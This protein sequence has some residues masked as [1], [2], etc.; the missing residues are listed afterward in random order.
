MQPLPPFH[1]KKEYRLPK[2]LHHQRPS[3]HAMSFLPT[4]STLNAG[5]YRFNPKASDGSRN[6]TLA[7]PAR[8][9]QTSGNKLEHHPTPNLRPEDLRTMRPRLPPK[10][11]RIT[12]LRTPS[13]HDAYTMRTPWYVP[14][15]A[16]Y[17]PLLQAM[18]S[19]SPTEAEGLGAE[20][21]RSNQ[22]RLIGPRPSSP[23][24]RASHPG[25][26]V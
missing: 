2:Y 16:P 10:R 6:A 7:K 26:P 23:R 22:G 4:G 19:E 8:S 5:F 3:F 15:V 9:I 17:T 14:L 11:R 25:T 12:W 20:G 18:R 24:H 13:V 1:V 21:G